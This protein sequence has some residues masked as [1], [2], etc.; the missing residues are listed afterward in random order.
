MCTKHLP[1]SYFRDMIKCLQDHFRHITKPNITIQTVLKRYSG[2]WT[3]DQHEIAKFLKG[4]KARQ[5]SV[6]I[7]GMDLRRKL[8]LPS[9]DKTIVKYSED[10]LMLSTKCLLLNYLCVLIGFVLPCSNS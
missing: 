3:P 8:E 2:I 6:Y 10:F 7:P 4:S 5:D 1:L 9:N